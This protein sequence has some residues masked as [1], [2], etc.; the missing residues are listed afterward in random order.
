MDSIDHIPSAD[1]DAEAGR[2]QRA[3]NRDS[4]F[5][6]GRLTLADENKERDVRIRNLSEGGLMIEIERKVALGTTLNLG[7]RGIGDVAGR[8]AWCAEGRIG[9]ALDERIDPKL[10]RKPVGGGERTPLFAK[11]QLG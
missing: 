9:V 2:S 6:M 3:K 10:A 8:V 11:P 1:H 7:L 4:L 5:L